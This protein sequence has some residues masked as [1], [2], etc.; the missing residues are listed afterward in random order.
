MPANTLFTER[1]PFRLAFS[2]N[3]TSNA[4][5]LPDR[6]LTLSMPGMNGLVLPTN[7][8]AAFGNWLWLQPFG[9]DAANETLDI[10]IFGYH[11]SVLSGGNSPQNQVHWEA[12][13]LL[14]VTCTLGTRQGLANT[15]VTA[16]D[17]YADTCTVNTA[18]S[19]VDYT[20]DSRAGNEKVVIKVDLSG[21]SAWVPRVDVGTAASANAIYRYF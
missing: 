9:T 20:V 19:G 11:H 15:L 8:I 5:G 18:P 21:Y 10:G 16:S 1:Q 2:S 4:K 6:E 13:L 3:D 7:A 17:F 14:D 12:D